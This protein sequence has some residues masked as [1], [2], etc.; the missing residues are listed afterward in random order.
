MPCF[1]FEDSDLFPIFWSAW[2]AA[3]GLHEPVLLFSHPK[4]MFLLLY[5]SLLLS[6]IPIALAYDTVLGLLLLPG[7]VRR[8]FARSL[9]W[10]SF[11]LKCQHGRFWDLFLYI[12]ILT[13]S[14]LNFFFLLWST[15]TLSERDDWS[16]AQER[17]DCFYLWEGT[18]RDQGKS[19]WSLSE[20]KDHCTSCILRT[21]PAG[22]CDLPFLK[23][24]SQKSKFH[25]GY[26]SGQAFNISPLRLNGCTG[27]WSDEISQAFIPL[28]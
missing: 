24:W 19:Q 13:Q 17:L 20:K 23:Q 11:K 28:L 7:K 5:C 8:L 18:A 9:L 2:W 25:S 14:L 15:E 12:Y 3:P 26:Y 10:F 21:S 1:Y 22:L 6:D 27:V 16:V 4:F